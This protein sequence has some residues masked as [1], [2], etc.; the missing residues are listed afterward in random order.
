ME[1]SYEV[2][3]MTRVELD[4]AVDW[5]AAEGWNPGRHDADAFYATDPNDFFVGL[6]DG[7]P[8][9]PISAVAYD[10]AFGFVGFY[11][12]KPELR[13]QGY[14]IQ[15]WRRAMEYLGARNRPRRGP[16]PASQLREVGLQASLPQHPLRWEE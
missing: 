7:E 12:V 6:L 15:V 3:P 8:I 1:R 4:V 13:G 9:A 11:I 10:G 2:R 5:A 16:R 14:G